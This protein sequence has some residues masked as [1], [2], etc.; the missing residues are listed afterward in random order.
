MRL[1]RWRKSKLPDGDFFLVDDNGYEIGPLNT[2]TMGDNGG[3]E[4]VWSTGSSP[5][6]LRIVKQRGDRVVTEDGGGDEFSYRIVQR[7]AVA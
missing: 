6:F 4:F 7:P 5:F 3:G 1:R 2:Q